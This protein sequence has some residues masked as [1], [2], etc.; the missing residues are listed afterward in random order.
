MVGWCQEHLWLR[1]SGDETVSK[2]KGVLKVKLK[3]PTES[4]KPGTIAGPL[5]QMVRSANIAQTIGTA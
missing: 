4:W 2:C 5:C 3:V 1:N